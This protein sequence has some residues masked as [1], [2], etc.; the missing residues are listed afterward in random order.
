MDLVALN[1]QRGRDHGLAPYVK[2]RQLCGLRSIKS[3]KMFASVVSSP[4]VSIYFF[5][6]LFVILVG[7]NPDFGIKILLKWFSLTVSTKA[8][9]VV[10]INRESRF[11]HW[12]TIGKERR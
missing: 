9:T 2:W 11:I 4:E 10:R 8:T 1:V 7:D 3:W 6:S 12:W 5:V